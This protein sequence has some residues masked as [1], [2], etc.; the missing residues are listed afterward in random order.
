MLLL[1]ASEPNRIWT[2]GEIVAA[3]RASDL[4]VRQSTQRLA[5][6]GLLQ[7][8]DGGLSYRPLTPEL[9]QRVDETRSL[10]QSSPGKVRRLIITAHPNSPIALADAFRLRKD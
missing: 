3:L 6:A 8:A 4:I 10:Y 2:N 7:I 1:L 5:G 9:A